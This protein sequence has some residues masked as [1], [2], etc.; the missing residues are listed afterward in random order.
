MYATKT[1]IEIIIDQFNPPG[2]N[3]K[4]C[5]YFN[6]LERGDGYF[7]CEVGYWI[8]YLNC[9]PI[10]KKETHNFQYKKLSK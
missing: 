5:N 8:T 9:K 4:D 10:Y 2:S 6:V 1:E 3:Y 7:R